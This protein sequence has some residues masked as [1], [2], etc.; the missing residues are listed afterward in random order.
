MYVC[1]DTWG[2]DGEGVVVPNPSYYSVCFSNE[3]WRHFHVFIHLATTRA[4][5]CRL[6]SLAS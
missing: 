1:V 3:S 2:S 5:S 4:L 6:I